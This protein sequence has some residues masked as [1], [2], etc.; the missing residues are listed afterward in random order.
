[1]ERDFLRMPTTMIHPG[2]ILTRIGL[3]VVAYAEGVMTATGQNPH[4]RGVAL[5]LIFRHPDATVGTRVEP[6]PK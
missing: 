5:S 4:R 3:V 2:L 6:P 1:M